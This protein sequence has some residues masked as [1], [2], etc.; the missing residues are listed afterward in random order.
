MSSPKIEIKD[1]FPRISKSCKN[2]NTCCKT[3]GWLLKKEAEK[4][5]KKGYSV[6]SLNDSTFCI[7]SFKK[8]GR[9]D[10]ILEEIP[11]CR[12]YQKRECFIQKNK[13][14]D[15]KLFPLKTKFYK[16]S[17]VLGLS[18]GCNY[19]SNLDDKE[20]KKLFQRVIK[21]IKEMNKKQLNEYLNLMQEVNSISKPKKF[22]MKKL[23][24]FKKDANSWELIPFHN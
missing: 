5:I 24:A 17:C 20:K 16:D 9:G 23:M 1:L 2:C 10:L 14:L 15:C 18:L 8:D 3:Y 7:D 21:F 11:R 4:F 12:F 19:I 22:W 6:I 13:P